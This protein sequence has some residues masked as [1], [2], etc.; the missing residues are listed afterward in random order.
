MLRAL[1]FVTLGAIATY[2][3]AIP[4]L[5]QLVKINHKG[6]YTPS[7]FHLPA[8]LFV[9][10]AIIPSATAMY[11]PAA[12][13][14]VPQYAYDYYGWLAAQTQSN[15]PTDRF[16]VKRGDM[17]DP[18]PT[19]EPFD[20]LAAQTDVINARTAAEASKY[21]LED[22]YMDHSPRNFYS[23]FNFFTDASP[24]K[25]FVEY[26]SYDAADNSTLIGFVP[27]GTTAPDSAYDFSVYAG[28]DFHTPMVETG[29]RRS[30]RVTSK[31]A[32]GPGM[33][34]VAEVDHLPTGCGTWP[35]IWLL[36]GPQEWP[37][38]GEIDI[39]E[40]VNGQN[41]NSMTL[42]TGP[43]CTL[44]TGNATGKYTGTLA[45]MNDCNVANNA[46]N[47]AGCQIAAPTN[48]PTF[49]EPFNAA[50]GGTYAAEWTEQGISIWFWS[51]SA[52][53]PFLPPASLITPNPDPNTFGI[54]VA[55][56]DGPGC[57]WG[58]KFENMNIVMNTELCGEW[59]GREQEW[60][61]SGCAAKAGGKTCDEWVRSKEGLEEA[62][63][64]VRGLRVYTQKK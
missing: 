37:L 18:L 2:S 34:L 9:A 19:D 35:A 45:T 17:P 43:G 20:L 10:A 60:N 16:E 49:G 6:K 57:D 31:K 12:T 21:I 27:P 29:G 36:G 46:N 41:R 13:P 51:K 5:G 55:K 3:A 62:F 30:V 52:K 56:F 8:V 28:I 26:V 4:S 1:T 38:S 47:N 15:P 39:I 7:A 40:G 58:K 11:D 24:T 33:L 54:P 61:D 53:A 14:A 63:W 23:K 64:V 50:G 22:D 59:A 44:G 42:H 32:Y 48:L 25:G